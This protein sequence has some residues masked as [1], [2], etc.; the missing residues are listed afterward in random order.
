MGTLL[1]FMGIELGIATVLGMQDRV[2]FFNMLLTN[3]ISVI[4]A[5][6]L[7]FPI[8]NLAGLSSPSIFMAF[9]IFFVAKTSF[10][11]YSGSVHQKD[12][13]KII[14]ID[15][16]ITCLF[17]SMGV[18]FAAWIFERPF[19]K[20]SA[21]GLM[22]PALSVGLPVTVLGLIFISYAVVTLFLPKKIDSNLEC[23]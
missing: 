18:E 22:G 16:L 1:A 2:H 20:L 17:A 14:L 23:E 8:S 5:F 10:V 11:L 4:V 15:Y 12:K 6:L 3:I 9:F 7:T 21:E 19:E 13:K